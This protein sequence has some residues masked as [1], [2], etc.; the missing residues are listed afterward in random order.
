MF[1]HTVTVINIDT[2]TN[3]HAINKCIVDDVFFYNK[4]IISQENK[5]ENYSNTYNCVFSNKAL[6]KYLEPKQY[7]NTSNKFTL[8]ENKT[9][10][11]KGIASISSLDDL[12]KLDNWFYVKTKLDNSDYGEDELRNI[13]VTNLK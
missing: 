4:K 7:I 8:I 1:P 6:E 5:G 13:E 2:S 10:I 11:I 9:I 12:N 3:P